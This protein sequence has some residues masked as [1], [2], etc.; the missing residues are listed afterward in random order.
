[1]TSLADTEFVVRSI[2]QTAVDNEKE[3][4]DLDAV[5]GAQAV[6]GLGE[7]LLVASHEHQT[8]AVACQ[9]RGESGADARCAARHESR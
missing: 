3:F 6:G 7:A 4:G 8:V 9:G 2:A 5:V 1:M